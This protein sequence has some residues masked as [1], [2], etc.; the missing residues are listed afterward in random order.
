M[1]LYEYVMDDSLSL[2]VPLK[3]P[4]NKTMIGWLPVP[5]TPGHWSAMLVYNGHSRRGFNGVGG[6]SSSLGA[7]GKRESSSV[8]RIWLWDGSRE[9]AIA[10]ETGQQALLFICDHETVLWLYSTVFII[11]IG[12]IKP[13]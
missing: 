8:S 1:G 9:R 12:V 3:P 4:V 10:G 2:Q 7:D 6:M 11:L 5:L 13:K